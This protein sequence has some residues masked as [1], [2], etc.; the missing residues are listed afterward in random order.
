MTLALFGHVAAVCMVS[1]HQII[2]LILNHPTNIVYILTGDDLT[3]NYYTLPLS[4]II[5]DRFMSSLIEISFTFGMFMLV[6][7]YIFVSMNYIVFYTKRR[8]YSRKH[9]FAYFSDPDRIRALIN[10]HNISYNTNRQ[11]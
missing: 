7:P 5:Y 2:V 6:S 9:R 3:V 11:Y 4:L 8:L 1:L 10:K